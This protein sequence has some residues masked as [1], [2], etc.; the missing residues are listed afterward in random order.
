MS[1]TVF[2]SRTVSTPSAPVVAPSDPKVL[3]NSSVEVPYTEYQRETNES[4]V[5]KRYDLGD[6]WNDPAGFKEEVGQIEKFFKGEIERG[7]LDNTTKAVEAKI[8]E[9]EQV[10]GIDKTERTVMKIA[11]LAAYVKFLRETQNLEKYGIL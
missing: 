5:A 1:D 11:K 2:R 4:Y 10:A 7:K 3:G 6:T 8:K 9:Y